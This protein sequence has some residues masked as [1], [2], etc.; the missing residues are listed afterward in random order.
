MKAK[1]IILIIWGI[2]TLPSCDSNYLDVK[3]QKSLMVP[4][5]LSDLEALL[6]N[7][8]NIMNVAGYLYLA[9]DGDFRINDT[10]LSYINEPIRINYLWSDE[11][12]AWIGDWDYAY[13]QIFYSNVVLKGLEKH[14]SSNSLTRELKGRALFYRAWALH[15]MAQQFAPHYSAQTASTDMGVP[16]PISPDVNQP[17]TRLTVQANYNQIFK[18]LNEAVSL[19]PELASFSTQPSKAAS[20][21]LLARMYLLTGDYVNALTA[22]R[23]ALLINNKLIDYKTL[24]PDL[25]NTFPLPMVNPNPEILFYTIGNTSFTGNN[26]TFVDSSLYDL[27]ENGDLRKSLYF[28]PTRNYKGSYSGNVLPFVGLATDEV[29]LIKAECETRTGDISEARQTL[30]TLRANR[31]SSAAFISIKEENPQLLLKAILLE[32]R[33]ELIGR[34]TTWSD[35]RR[36]NNE[37][38]HERTLNRKSGGNTYS[39]EPLSNRYT[40]KI[41][42][43][44]VNISGIE[45][46]K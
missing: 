9:A 42:M 7:S 23:Q 19:L 5:T 36:L 22:A 28:R 39:L 2:F 29:F 18:D 11:T 10:Y 8:R 44:E 27:Y 1:C 34:G 15:L 4:E 13:T 45:Q 32:R 24:N 26:N 25:S 38:G 43:D 17:I 12:T 31:Y 46:N 33:K 41:P 21:A 40:M 30:N 37:A 35:L 3:P 16:F 14:D 20:Y 6:N